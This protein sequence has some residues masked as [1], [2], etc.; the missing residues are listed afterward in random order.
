MSIA[1]S[2]VLGSSLLTG[3]MIEPLPKPSLML[4]NAIAEA[5]SLEWNVTT[6]QEGDYFNYYL[7]SVSYRKQGKIVWTSSLP[8]WLTQ[9]AIEQS[10]KKPVDIHSYNG[11]PFLLGT[12]FTD[13]EIFVADSSGVFVLDRNTGKILKDKP[14]EPSPDLFFV[15]WGTASITT[16]T[17][18]CDLQIQGGQFLSACGEVLVYFNRKNLWVWNRS[19]Q[20]VESVNYSQSKHKIDTHRP[21]NYKARI[22]LKTVV[23]EISGFVGE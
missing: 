8:K 18:R 16:Q 2:P 21:L 10:Y 12:V 11:F 6:Q 19:N 4:S 15:D 3:K 20:L 22:S 13:S 5:S 14:A 9:K 1:A 7:A 17:Q 23:V